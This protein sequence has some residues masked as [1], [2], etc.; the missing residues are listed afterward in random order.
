M[1]LGR[2]RFFFDMGMEAQRRKG[3]DDNKKKGWKMLHP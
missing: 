1:G 3:L 2:V